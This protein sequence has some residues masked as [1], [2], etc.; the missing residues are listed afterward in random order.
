LEH[1]TGCSPRIY[2]T[3]QS[4][5]DEENPW[6]PFGQEK[7][8]EWS[9]EK[10]DILFL[11]GMDWVSIPQP[12]RNHFPK[13]VINLIQSTRHANPENP[14]YS[15]LSHRAVRICVSQEVQRAIEETGIVNGPVFTIM[16]GIDLEEIALYHS[17]HTQRVYTV[18]IAGL[19]NP[20]LAAEIQ[21]ALVNEGIKSICLTQHIPRSEFLEILSYS[22]IAVVLPMQQE[23]YF[24]PFW[25]AVASGCLAIC[26]MHDGATSQFQDG[27]N[28]FFPS[29]C[30][31]E[32]IRSINTSLQL[33]T[34]EADN[35]KSRAKDLIKE[36]TIQRERTQFLE[37][38]SQVRSLY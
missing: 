7:L 5:L 6:F 4:Q 15:F 32:I 34:L 14:L 38:L 1:T 27:F 26:P 12:Q 10:A 37:I 17:G 36:R 31:E 25:E 30:K 33:S 18:C 2:F 19:K 3:G 8:E 16:N 22:E 9:P 21:S 11:G 35:I 13:P 29:Y 24:L 23:G 28:G 20:E